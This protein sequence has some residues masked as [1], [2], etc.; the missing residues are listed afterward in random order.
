MQTRSMSAAETF[1]STAVGF[2][3]SW[4]LTILVLPLFGYQVTL[5]HSAGITAIYTAASILRGYA[6]RRLFSGAWR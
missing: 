5:G 1:T 3:V 2:L 6:I 4:G